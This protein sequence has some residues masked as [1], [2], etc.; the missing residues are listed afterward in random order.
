MPFLKLNNAEVLF[1]EETLMWK[2][3]TTNKVLPTIK[4]VQLINPQ[5]FVI[6]ALNADNKTFIVYIAI[7]EQK[8]I[9]I[10][11]NKKAQIKAQIKAQS[12]AQSRAKSGVQ[13]R[14]LIFDK[15][16]IEVL[17]E[18]FDYN[19]VFLVENAVE[20]PENTRINEHAIELKESKQPS[21]GPIY[22]LGP[23]ELETLK[24]YIE[25]NLNNSFIR[26]SKSP[27]GTSIFF[28]QKPDRS[29]RFCVDYRCFKNITIKN[30]YPLPLIDELLDWLG[31][32]KQF[33]QLN[34][35]K[36]YH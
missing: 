8:E 7:R 32:A 5:E 3:Y 34:L 15:A 24:T 28:D 26:P 35:T 1:G 16:P 17:A 2:S 12:G 22:N 25:T 20:L 36:A 10:D 13:V 27:A 21:F 6:A 33:T 9:A 11:P 30:W 4:Q 23:V 14:A 31:R 18:Y 19:N 29:L